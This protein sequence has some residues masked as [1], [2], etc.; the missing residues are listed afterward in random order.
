MD[1]NLNNQTLKVFWQHAWRYKRYV[2]ALLISAPL[3]TIFLRLIPPLIAA[4][5]IRRLGAGEFVTGDFWGSFSQ[6]III[7]GIVSI[8]G[9]VILTRVDMYLVWKL[10]TY[11]NRDLIRTMFNH[12]LKLDTGFHENSFG[13]SLVSRANKLVGSYIRLADTFIFQLLPTLVS[14]IFILIVMYPKSPIFAYGFLLLSLIFVIVTY[15]YSKRVR[16][17]SAMESD[18]DHKTTGALA[19]AVT[20]VMAIKSFASWQF[21]KKKFADISEF[22]RQRALDVMRATLVRDFFASLITSGLQI[23]AV[24]VA[25]I[26]I[27]EKN[28]DLAVVFLMLSYASLAADYLWQFSSQILRNFSRSMGDAERAI[29]T[30]NRQPQIIDAK[31]PEPLKISKGKIEFK[32]ITF[33]HA[34]LSDA[35][36]SL[37]QNLNIEINHGEKI[38]LVGRS[39]GGKTTITKLLLR[40]MDINTGEILIDGQN[41][42]K[43]SQ[44]NLRSVI[45]YVPQ[46]PLLFHRS[47]A[48]N[49]SYGAND[50]TKEEIIKAS[51]MAHAHEFI[52]KLTDGYGTLVGERGVKLSGGQRQRVAIA[53]AMLKDAPILLLDEA[54]SALDSESE[55]LIQDALWKLMEGKTTIVI[56]HRLS[57]IQKMDRILVLENGQIVESGNHK[58]LIKNKGIYSELWKHQSGGFIED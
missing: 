15:I 8:I 16:D 27:V 49:I 41:I 58:E 9:G 2:I 13:G 20:N 29:K 25:I 26:A 17:L 54:T 55:K 10:E 1:K 23:A 18:A 31:N 3:A 4:E 48:E 35:D 32:N 21:E 6:D 45:T 40:Y 34:D 36:D 12:Y 39:G 53:R 56:A 37:F 46:E 7:Y 19:D 22:T 38:G 52:E 28:S 11:V 33:D 44:D 5:I 30:L 47:L 57:T 42:S 51:K 14:F 50:A 24:V 43:I